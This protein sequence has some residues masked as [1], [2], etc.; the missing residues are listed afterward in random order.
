MK[1]V[2]RFGI[3][4]RS[5]SNPFV[6]KSESKFTK[7]FY[8]F[9]EYK[10]IQRRNS[11][12]GK[13]VLREFPQIVRWFKNKYE[14][15]T[16]DP[17]FKDAKREDIYVDFMLHLLEKESDVVEGIN[18]EEEELLRKLENGEITMEQYAKFWED[19]MIDEKDNKN[20]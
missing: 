16:T 4:T 9:I 11:A 19:F 2:L 7:A 3:N 17:R 10:P 13:I 8:D 18:D 15:S 1:L 6:K 5:L 20:G 12:I 14:Y